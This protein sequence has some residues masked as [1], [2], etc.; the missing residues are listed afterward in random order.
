MINSSLVQSLTKFL[1]FS[2]FFLFYVSRIGKSFMMVLPLSLC[3]YSCLP[4]SRPQNSAL[5]YNYDGLSEMLKA[6][7]IYFFG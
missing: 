3:H 2:F 5:V 7:D 1:K 6:I 4:S